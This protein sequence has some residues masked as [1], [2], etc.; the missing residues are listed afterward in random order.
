MFTLSNKT[1]K[2]IY[3]ASWWGAKWREALPSGN[4]VI[5]AAVYGGVYKETV[6][7]N[8]ANLWWKGVT[9][10]LPDVSGRLPAVRDLLKQGRAREADRVLPDALE[11]A[12]YRA[13]HAVPLPLGDFHILMPSQQAFRDYT[14]ELNMDSGEVT[15]SWNEGDVRYERGLFVSRVDDAVVYEIR[16]SK[17]SRINCKAYFDLHDESDGVRPVDPDVLKLR[18]GMSCAGKG[19]VLFYAACNENA[20]DFGAVTTI[21]IEEGS[22]SYTDGAFQITN[23]SRVTF[24]IKCFATGHREHRW[25]ELEGQLRQIPADYETLLQ[26]HVR[27]HARLFDAMSFRLDHGEQER[28]NEEYLMEA[29]RG[30]LSLAMIAKMWAYGRYLLISSTREGGQPCHL[31][32]L[33]CGEYNALWTFHMVNENL[34][35]IY[36]QAFSGNMPQILLPVFDYMDG[37]LDDF[38]MNASKLYGCRGIFVPAPTTPE[39]GLLKINYPHI[40][41]WISGAGWVAQFYAKYYDYTG[42]IAFLRDRA[43]PFL[44]ETSLFYEDYLMIGEDG[45]YTVSPSVSPENTPGNYAKESLLYDLEAEDVMETTINATMDFAIAK[46]VL[47]NLI[48]LAPIVGY[49][50]EEVEKWRSMLSKIP[51]YQVNEQGAIREWMHPDF[52]DNDQHRHLSHVYPLFPGTEMDSERPTPLY[53]AFVQAVNNRSQGESLKDQSNWSVMHLANTWAVIGDGDKAEHC[54]DRLARSSVLGNFFTLSNDWRDMGM[55]VNLPW[56]PF[57]IDANMGWSAA[58]QDMLMQSSAGKIRLL[59]ALPKRWKRGEANGLLAYGGIEVSIRWD[60]ERGQAQVE[61]IAK[62]SDSQVEIVMKEERRWIELK[63]NKL[64]EL[65]FNQL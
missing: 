49:K 36:W 39:S 53:D 17:R 44:Y 58:V 37:K 42:D 45:Y 20:Q 23:A 35:M 56:A 18:D 33:W 51:P 2:L 5:G 9:K 11:E 63:K 54:L 25:Q 4:G 8:H 27:E 62:A 43:L 64:V 55:S 41:H 31:Y 52:T 13:E 47:S 40:V 57:Q 59:P 48:R 26:R 38:R 16:A 32:G 6:L 21:H 29:Y 24:I 50:L 30:K 19:N 61:L 12:D 7:L 22:L 60:I 65:N 28:F 34:Q 14:R 1:L 10:E 46:E 3:P 15:V